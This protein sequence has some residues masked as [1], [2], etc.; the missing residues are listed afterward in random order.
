M[1]LVSL[2]KTVK[3]VKKKNNMEI[4]IFYEMILM[5]CYC[6]NNKKPVHI[7]DSSPDSALPITQKKK[8]G[9]KL[10][11]VMPLSISTFK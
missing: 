4:Y 10:E 1:K 2:C 11:S 6:K 8:F 7:Q 5:Q 3:M 9:V